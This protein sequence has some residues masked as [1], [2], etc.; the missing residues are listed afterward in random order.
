MLHPGAIECPTL[1]IHDP[2][3]PVAPIDH[4]NWVADCIPQAERCLV[5]AGG[6]F[7]WIGKDAVE[8]HRRRVVFL[9]Q[10]LA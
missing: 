4:A 2:F 3:D 7:V 1:L 8:M 5:H 9:R 6:H 10:N